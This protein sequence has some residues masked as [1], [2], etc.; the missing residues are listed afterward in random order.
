MKVSY[1]VEK[2][3]NGTCL[4]RRRQAA[5]HKYSK[6]DVTWKWK[7]MEK[8]G[9]EESKKEGTE[10]GKCKEKKENEREREAII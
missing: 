9:E 3:R 1:G 5:G 2:Y 6:G 4:T 8:E 10:E 7:V